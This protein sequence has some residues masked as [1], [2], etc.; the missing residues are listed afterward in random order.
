MS[1][2]R[3]RAGSSR[4]NR[5]GQPSGDGAVRRA[6]RATVHLRH[7][8]VH[9]GHR[10][11]AGRADRRELLIRHGQYD[12]RC[13]PARP[14]LPRGGTRRS[15]QGAATGR[16]GFRQVGEHHQP[17]GRR[18]PDRPANLLPGPVAAGI[19]L[20]PRDESDRRPVR[21][22]RPHRER[23]RPGSTDRI[24]AAAAGQHRDPVRPEG[25]A[26]QGHHGRPVPRSQRADRWL[27]RRRKPRREAYD[28]RPGGDPGGVPERA[29]AE[30]R[31]RA[32]RECR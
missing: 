11:Q 5:S 29:A 20:P 22:V 27:R 2:P 23:V 31:C 30:R 7:G 13:A 26:G 28:S 9:H 4:G 18:R 32:S 21:R 15:Q 14:L 3:R 25:A 12:P 24:R 6:A 10:E 16:L 17:R 1:S 8:G 19:A